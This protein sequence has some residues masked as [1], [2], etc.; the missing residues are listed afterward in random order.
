MPA[1]P[2]RFTVLSRIR[3]SVS[4]WPTEMPAVFV[5]SIVFFSARPYLTPQQKNR[6]M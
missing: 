3:L 4:R 2:L 5:S 1:C 6:P